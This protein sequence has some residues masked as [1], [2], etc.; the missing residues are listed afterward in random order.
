MSSVPRP[1]SLYLSEDQ[2]AR[3]VLG[4]RKAKD[5]GMLVAVWERE[6]LP[7]I[8]ALVG[9]RYWPAVRRWLDQRN[10]L[11]QECVPASADGKERWSETGAA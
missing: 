8:D 5:W 11:L 4:A 1:P 6:G 10:G 7:R 9:R 3:R 2:I